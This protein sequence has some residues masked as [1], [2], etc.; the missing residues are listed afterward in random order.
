MAAARRLIIVANRLPVNRTGSGDSAKWQSS[1]GGLVTA[2]A[3][4]LRQTHGAWVGWPGTAGQALRSFTHEGLRIKPVPLSTS[5][6]EHYYHGLSNRTLWPLYHDAIRTPEFKRQWWWPY[7][8][9]NQ[10][11]AKAAAAVAREGDLVWIHDYHLQLVPK[12]LRELRPDLR[13]G[14]FLHTPF[15]PE[16]IFAWL[17]WRRQVLE[18]LMGA[19]VVGF[20]TAPSA[21]NFSRAA[22]YFTD[23]EGTDTRLDMG[24]R[25]VRVN[26]FPISI[27]NGWFE[28]SGSDPSIVK[29]AMEIRRR[30]G[31]H[32]KIILGVDR[33]DY[34]KGIEARLQAFELLL[35]QKA[36]SVERCVMMQIAVP[37]REQ[38]GEYAATR[39]AIEH[40]VGRING[41]HSIPGRVA[42][43]YFRRGYSREEL[44]PYY[45]AADVMLV[46][47]L[48]DGM[49]LVAKEYVA[50]RTDNTGVL[51][52]SEFA[53]A[54]QELRRALLVNPRDLEGT[55]AAIQAALSLPKDDARQRMSIL[56]MVV[57]R[58]DVH[59]WAES[60]LEAMRS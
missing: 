21:R 26:A 22:R 28:S 54:A 20:Q 1:A 9:V 44:I 11:F 32:R 14:F 15:P 52:L 42:V 30:I 59:D 7:V 39:K 46:T 25:E 13:I 8:D 48:R 55:A 36:V 17:P 60:F 57:R 31:S 40:T 37:S 50:T 34:T 23:A 51:V 56:R 18:G 24:G 16:E 10:R 43:H 47:P 58:H 27:D 35:K 29:Q 38:V 5:E 53:G 6:V 49:N 2:L 12:M 4:V 3:P 19:D 41:D 45:R 33:L